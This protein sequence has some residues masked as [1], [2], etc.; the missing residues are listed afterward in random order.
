MPLKGHGAKF[1][2]KKEAAITALLTEKS[3]AD[4]ARS[5]GIGVATLG[6]WRKDPEFDAACREASW[7]VS[8]AQTARMKQL[9]TKAIETIY[10]LMDDPNCP[11][12]S[13]IGAAL[14]VLGRPSPLVETEADK[15]PATQLTQEDGHKLVAEYLKVYHEHLLEMRRLQK[16]LKRITIV[17]DDSN[18]KD[19]CDIVVLP[20]TSSSPTP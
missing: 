16:E 20:K 13:Q 12:N 9:R 3:V 17:G 11:P 18:V 19:V 5:V 8:K 14:D 7:D 4:A 15:P 1:G 10:T 2:R 6:R